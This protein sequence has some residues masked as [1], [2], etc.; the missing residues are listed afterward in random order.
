MKIYT[1]GHKF[2]FTE[3]Y[4]ELINS[5]LIVRDFDKFIELAINKRLELS[6]KNI[7][8]NLS[9]KLVNDTIIR[10]IPML[11]KRPLIK[12]YPNVLALFI[13][14]RLSGLGDIE[15][16]GKKRFLT[17]DSEMLEQWKQFTDV[18]KYFYLFSLTFA[19]FSFEPIKDDS[20]D[21]EL[22]SI[23]SLI[24]K[25]KKVWIPNKFENDYI[26][27]KYK[28]KTVLMAMD[29]FGLIDI[30]EEAPIENQ[31]WNIVSIKPKRFMKDIWEIINQLI[32]DCIYPIYNEDEE[33]EYLDSFTPYDIKEIGGTHRFADFISEIIP[34]FTKRLVINFKNI[35]GNYHFKAKYGKVW[36]TIKIDYRLLLDDLCIAILYA[37]DFDLD[38][39]YDVKFISIYGFRITL[40]GTPGMSYADYPTTEDITI[41]LLPIQINS[42]MIFTFDYRDNWKFKITLEKIEPIKNETDEIPAPE[43]IDKKGEAPKQYPDWE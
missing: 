12:S 29:M 9:C 40:N 32:I 36:R 4:I 37:F 27:K 22:N 38:H 6:K 35:S 18:D 13:L 7:L 19:N 28:Y 17:V 33:L 5:S 39:L 21:F 31:G 10:K 16:K 11:M 15:I 8:N 41:G 43:L 25:K 3:D 14:Y 24:N 30:K 26:F 1:K 23:I 20:A 2:K 42:E 34:E